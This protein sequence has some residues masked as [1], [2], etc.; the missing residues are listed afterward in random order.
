M[1]VRYGGGGWEE[2]ERE[3]TVRCDRGRERRRRLV[4]MVVVVVVDG[5]RD[6]GRKKMIH[7]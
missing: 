7:Q 3:R 2:W 5:Q 1:C 6:K 4:V